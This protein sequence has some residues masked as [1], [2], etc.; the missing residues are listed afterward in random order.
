MWITHNLYLIFQGKNMGFPWCSTSILVYPSVAN[1]ANMPTWQKVPYSSIAATPLYN[2]LS[3]TT[4]HQ[5]IIISQFL[6]VYCTWLLNVS[7]S[8]FYRT[9]QFLVGGIPNPLKNDGV[10]QLGSVKFPTESKKIWSKPPTRYGCTSILLNLYI[11]IHIFYTYS[12]GS[13]NPN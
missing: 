6:T 7:N 3:P 5:R 2:R 8:F 9:R 13:F 11:Y 10:R 1:F 12:L 4:N